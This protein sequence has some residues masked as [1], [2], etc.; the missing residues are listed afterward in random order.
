M[1][2]GKHIYCLKKRCTPLHK[3]LIGAVFS[4]NP[5]W[6]Y[7]VLRR[8]MSLPT[9]GWWKLNSQ[10]T[11]ILRSFKVELTTSMNRSLPDLPK[12]Q[13]WQF[14]YI[15]WMQRNYLRYQ[16]WLKSI[17]YTEYM[18]TPLQIDLEYFL[19]LFLWISQQFSDCYD[20][21]FL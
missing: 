12:Y 10:D 11:I 9:Q 4:R 13:K 17:F 1:S 2:W 8:D 16:A 14:I 6:M 3:K 15:E 7:V 19:S 5:R 18:R 21:S 20:N